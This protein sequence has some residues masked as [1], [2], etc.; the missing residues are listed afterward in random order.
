METKTI[1]VSINLPRSYRVG[2]L[3]Q[4]LTAYAYRLIAQSKR[5]KRR[6]RHETLCGIFKS[7]A[8]EDELIEEYL[9]EKYDIK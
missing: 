5:A 1:T 3:Q 8:T 9:K 7:N 4:Q 6:Y 2:L